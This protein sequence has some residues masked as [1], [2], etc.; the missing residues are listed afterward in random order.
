VAAELASVAK[1]GSIAELVSSGA[2]D[3]ISAALADAKNANARE[4]GLLAIASLAT[5]LGRPAEPYL[6]PLLGQ[7]LAAL[8][9]KAA[10]VRDAAVAAQVRRCAAIA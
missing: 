5:S 7:V 10:P 8:A 1:A 3:A 6:V 4:G 2:I 9:D